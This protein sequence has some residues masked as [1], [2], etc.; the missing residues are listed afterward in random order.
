MSHRGPGV[1]NKEVQLIRGSKGIE[2][3]GRDGTKNEIRKVLLVL[4]Y[5]L[6]LPLDT[7]VLF[8]KEVATRWKR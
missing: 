1:G 3:S 4:R 8:L 2:G 5:A 7:T 6:I